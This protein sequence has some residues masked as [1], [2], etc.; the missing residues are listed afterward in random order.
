MFINNRA[1][2]AFALIMFGLFATSVSNVTD[3]EYVDSGRYNETAIDSI[4]IDAGNVT[5]LNLTSNVSTA[6]WAGFKGNVTGNIFLGDSTDLFYTWAWE[7]AA[8]STAVCA[9]NESA[10]DF[11]AIDN[12]TATDIEAAWTDYDLGMDSAT[13]TFNNT[14]TLTINGLDIT[15]SGA[16]DTTNPTAATCVA[17][18]ATNL[19]FCSATLDATAD[20]YNFAILVP[21]DDAET[22]YFFVELV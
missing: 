14:C 2:L 6:K 20:D 8:G 18:D 5:T 21:A 19:A 16:A 22:Y 1:I 3:I 10:F 15:A 13:N 12:A 11:T 4:S 7:Q 9:T 17:T